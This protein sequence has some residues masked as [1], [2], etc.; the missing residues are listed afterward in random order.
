MSGFKMTK[1]DL[2]LKIINKQHYN[3]TIQIIISQQ[4][5]KKQTKK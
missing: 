5:K 3:K 4:T 1:L 2:G